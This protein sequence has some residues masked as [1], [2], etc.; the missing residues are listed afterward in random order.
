[1]PESVD[2]DEDI[3]NDL[4]SNVKLDDLRHSL[5]FIAGLQAAS[6]DDPAS[7]LD[8]ETIGRLR[9][10]PQYPATID[11]PHVRAALE[12]YMHL[13]HSD[14][15]FDH[16]RLSYIKGNNLDPAEFPTLYQTKKIAEDITGV[17][18]VMHDMCPNSCIG[19]TGPFSHLEHCPECNEFRYDQALLEKTSGL[20]HSPDWPQIQA[21]YRDP[22][23]AQEMCYRDEKT[24]D[25]F[26]EL[27]RRG[28]LDSYSDFFDGD[29]YIKAVQGRKIKDDDIILMMSVDGAQLYKNKQSDCWI[30]IWIKKFVIP[31][32]V[33]PGPNKPK[34]L[35]SFLYPS[36]HHAAAIMKEGLP[37]WDAH[38]DVRYLSNLFLA[39]ATADG[40]GLM[41]LNGLVG[42]HG[43]MGAVSTV[44]SQDASKPGG[45]HYYP[46]LK[47][48]LDYDYWDNLVALLSSRTER[49]YQQKR[50]ETGISKPSI[51]LGFPEHCILGVPWC[52][53]SDIMHLCSLN[54]P[55]LLIPLWRGTFKCDPTD[56]VSTW[57]HGRVVAASSRYLPGFFDRPPRNLAEKISSGYKA[58]E[59]TLYMWGLGPAVFHDVLPDPYWQSFCKLVRGVRLI[60]QRSIT[61]E[62]LVVAARCFAEFEDEFE[63]LYYQ[64][65]ADRLH[66]VRQSV[67]APL[68]YANEV[69][70]K[71]PLICSSQWPMDQIHQH[72]N[73]FANLGQ[74]C[75][76]QAQTNTLKI[77]MPALDHDNLKSTLPAWAKD[78]GGGF[79]LLAKHDRTA[80]ATTISESSAIQEY[81]QANAPQSPTLHLFG[82]GPVK[83][84]RSARLRLPSGL[85]TRSLWCEEDREHVWQARNIRLTYNGKLQFAEVYY[86]FQAIIHA[87]RPPETLAVITL[88]SPPDVKLLQASHYTLW[89][90]H[91][92]GDA[93]LV[94][95]NVK[96]IESVVAMVPHKINGE[97]RFY[98][99]EKPGLDVADMGG[100]S[101]PEDADEEDLF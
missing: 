7:G 59:Y 69:F 45:S 88:Y 18:S 81:V 74:R 72:S 101:I 5:A 2:A 80:R 61:R 96:M 13:K 25:I 34:N 55:D 63:D 97:D 82:P 98:V 94:V 44:D 32:L 3:L 29:D 17:Y 37:I 4:Y 78:I 12:N 42:H 66:F 75:L 68:H 47:K 23:S 79:A 11:D 14:S 48:P 30:S 89:S 56:H 76:R 24:Q 62:E 67:H 71:G 90:C 77:I 58:W 93:A 54:L 9:N 39:I 50:L 49:E 51:F 33:V 64:Q 100:Y 57:D 43:K 53:G 65:R 16:A 41:Y 46:A 36:F 27:E 20:S 92:Q 38:R 70:T 19:Y 52:F 1:M 10:P 87:D 8:S 95:I 26:E 83:V 28:S 21:L 31:G 6:L 73:P 85:T 22:Q 60:S 40:P 15:D 86:F 99:V 35:D 84:A 91:H